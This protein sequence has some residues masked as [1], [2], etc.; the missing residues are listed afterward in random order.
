MT[1]WKSRQLH[2]GIIPFSDLNVSQIKAFKDL[3]FMVALSGEY[4]FSLGTAL[5]IGKVK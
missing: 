4:T 1:V 2:D 5:S 3:S